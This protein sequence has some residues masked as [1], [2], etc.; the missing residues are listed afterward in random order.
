MKPASGVPAA[1]HESLRLSL[2]EQGRECVKFFGSRFQPVVHPFV[3]LK[4]IQ[5]RA[6]H[7]NAA[8]NWISDHHSRADILR[9]VHH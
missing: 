7:I 5:A 4:H 3:Q 6:L 2:D 1:P 9:V 8:T